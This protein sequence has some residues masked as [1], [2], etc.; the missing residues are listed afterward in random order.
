MVQPLNHTCPQ[1]GQVDRSNHLLSCSLKRQALEKGGGHGWVRMV[2][3]F[4]LKHVVA[5]C[6]CRHVL[7]P[8]MDVVELGGHLPQ[9]ALLR[10]EQPH[11]RHDALLLPPMALHAAARKA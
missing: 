3:E 9:L 6:R 11:E 8:P 2:G 4:R 1:S 7:S 10:E 5:A